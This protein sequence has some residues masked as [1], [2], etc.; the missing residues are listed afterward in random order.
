MMQ[1]H[2]S[3]IRPINFPLCSDHL[4]IVFDVNVGNFSNL[5]ISDTA[6]LPQCL[7]TSGKKCSVSKYLDYVLPQI[8]QQIL[9]KKLKALYDMA[10]DNPD[11]FPPENTQQLNDIDSLLWE[12]LLAVK[13]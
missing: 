13:R 9:L 12:N 7:L 2:N 1:S 3:S 8:T 11:H 4:G 5:R 10:I 6:I